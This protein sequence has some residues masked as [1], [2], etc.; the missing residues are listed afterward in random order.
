VFYQNAGNLMSLE[1]VSPELATF[2]REHLGESSPTVLRVY[3]EPTAIRA[4]S[5]RSGIDVTSVLVIAAVAIPNLLRSRMAANEASAVGSMRS[6]NTAQVAYSASYEKRG[7]APNLAAL[8]PAANSPTKETPEHSGL[9]S[10]SL[11]GADCTGNAWCEKSGYRFQ[12]VSICKLN[13][14]SDYVSF[15]APANEN[16]GARTF[17]STSDGVIRY[18]IDSTVKIVPSVAEC[19][20]WPELK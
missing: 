1:A 13:K 17:C 19:R 12:V 14:C 5:S 18:K 15:A 6:I 9:L 20:A 11:A 10:E 7:Y 16:T 4:T 3:G 2:L 8:G